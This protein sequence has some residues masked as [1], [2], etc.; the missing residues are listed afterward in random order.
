MKKLRL[1]F[2][3]MMTRALFTATGILIAL[4]EYVLIVNNC[5]LNKKVEN[6]YFYIGNII[7]QFRHKK[8]AILNK[9]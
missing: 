5:A 2:A 9:L 6:K 8:M 4:P 7:I 3:M 1:G